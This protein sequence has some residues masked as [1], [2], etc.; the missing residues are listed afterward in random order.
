MDTASNKL[1]ALRDRVVR[2]E[3]TD[4][5]HTTGKLTGIKRSK[6]VIDDGSGAAAMEL[7]SSI[8][9]DHEASFTHDLTSVVSIKLAAAVVKEIV[10]HKPVGH[11]QLPTQSAKPVKVSRFDPREFAGFEDSE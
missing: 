8:V 3:F 9:L 2:V 11:A 4:G 6:L 10:S 7:P 5:S 1:D